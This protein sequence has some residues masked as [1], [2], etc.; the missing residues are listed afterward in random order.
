VFCKLD[1]EEAYDHVN[2]S[3]FLYMLRSFLGRHGVIG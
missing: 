2:W 3:F 1:I